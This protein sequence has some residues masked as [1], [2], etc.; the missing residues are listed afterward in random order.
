M[1]FNKSI[2]AFLSTQVQQ[3][4]LRQ[5]YLAAIRRGGSGGTAFA[6]QDALRYAEEA[7]RFI[8]ASLPDELKGGSAHPISESDLQV[9]PVEITP[10][11]DF[12]IRMW[13]NP[14]A[15]HRLYL[16][17]SRFHLYL[18]TGLLRLRDSGQPRPSQLRQC[19]VVGLDERHD[20]RGRDFSRHAGRQDFQCP[21][22]VAGHDVLPGLHYLRA[23]GILAQRQFRKEVTLLYPDSGG[24]VTAWRSAPSA[25]RGFRSAAVPP[26]TGRAAPAQAQLR[27]SFSSSAGS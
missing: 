16:Y 19:P 17:G 14:T 20:R 10:S 25:G 12:L 11:G 7:K 23:A 4:K 3:K 8:I 2:E 18:G 5:H 9:G 27:P 21:A 13:W 6:Q 1:D 22:P 26:S 15:V 24:V